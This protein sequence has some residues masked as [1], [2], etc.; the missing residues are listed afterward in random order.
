MII[1]SREQILLLH[2]QLI[3]CYGGKSGVRD[4][5]LLDSAI[6][7]PNQSFGGYDFFPTIIDKA[8]RLC[9]GLVK[10]HP[11]YDGNKRIGAL[12]LLTTLDLNNINLCISSAELADIILQLAADT[13]SDE[14]FLQWVKDHID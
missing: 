14:F 3:K 12:V 7:A 9:I 5:C 2:G 13:I 11:F 8:V 6:N 4:A 1:L 10:N